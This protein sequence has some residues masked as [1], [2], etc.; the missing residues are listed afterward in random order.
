MYERMTSP[1]YYLNINPDGLADERALIDKTTIEITEKD[2]KEK[3]R[4]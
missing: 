4:R 3:R 2:T 1:A